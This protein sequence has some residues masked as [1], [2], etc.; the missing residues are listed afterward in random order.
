VIVDEVRAWEPDGAGPEVAIVALDPRS[1]ADPRHGRKPRLP[2]EQ[3]DRA[4][5]AHRSL[6]PMVEP[7]LQLAA[8]PPPA[9]DGAAEPGEVTAS[10]LE[11]VAA[12]GVLPAD[13]RRPPPL[14]VTTI[15]GPSGKVL[16]DARRD[17]VPD[18]GDSVA[19][20]VRSPHSRAVAARSLALPPEGVVIPAGATGVSEGRRDAWIV[21]YAP[22][23]VL[24]VWTGFDD[25][26]PLDPGVEG[27]VA[28]L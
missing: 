10:L 4:T 15:Q 22:D 7:L 14:A 23:L 21:G 17:L 16:L 12:Y 3:L 13:G 26:R 11:L 8:I 20:A 18:V 9:V 27:R 6:G 24:G 1:G 28:S 2:A 19:R 5:R 25:E